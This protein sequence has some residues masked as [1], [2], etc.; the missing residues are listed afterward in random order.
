MVPPMVLAGREEM[1]EEVTEDVTAEHTADDTAVEIIED[2]RP[3]DMAEDTAAEEIAENA[4]AE[5]I[6][7]DTTAE[8]IAEDATPTEMTEK[9]TAEKMAEETAAEEIID[10]AATEKIATEDATDDATAEDTADERT[11]V[12]ETA[13][14]ETAETV[15]RTLGVPRGLGETGDE[16]FCVFRVSFGF[17]KL[18]VQGACLTEAWER[19]EAS[20]ASRPLARSRVVDYSRRGSRK[21]MRVVYMPSIRPSHLPAP[22]LDRPAPIMA[23]QDPANARRAEDTLRGLNSLVILRPAVLLSW[24]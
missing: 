1:V 5:E 2:A 14:D 8:E 12:D 10:D 18:V 20:C 6:T 9:A 3:E 15:Q 21:R 22:L 11:S 17:A 23:K 4:T 19:S 16:T 24:I 13:T 7:E